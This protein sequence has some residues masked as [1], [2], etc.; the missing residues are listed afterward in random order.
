M[1]STIIT[2]TLIIFSFFTTQTY[3]DKYSPLN[4]ITTP[5]TTAKTTTTSEVQIEDIGWMDQSRM[6]QQITRIDELAQTKIGVTLQ[7][8]LADLETLQRIIDKELVAQDDYTTQLAMGTVLGNVMLADFPNTLVWKN[9]R[10]IQGTSVSLCVKNTSECLFP[11]T[12]LTRRMRVGTK[13]NVKKIY[14][15]A[16]KLME[17]HLPKLPYSEEIM[18]KLK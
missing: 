10:D 4:V 13:P 2:S 11:M 3:A 8:D 15:D 16:I 12:M 6:S 7:Q 18:H 1:K 5:K 9:Y 14:Y 17:K